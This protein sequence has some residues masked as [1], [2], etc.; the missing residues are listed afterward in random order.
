MVR[1]YTEFK[2]QF[3]PDYVIARSDGS[4]LYTLVNPVDDALMGITHVLRGEDL[5]PSTPR[6]IALYEALI[7]IGVA[8]Q[9]PQFAHLPFVMELVT[10]SFLSVIQNLTS[11][12]TVIVVSSR[13]DSSTTWPCWGGAFPL[14]AIFSALMNLLRTSMLSM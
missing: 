1:G 6:Q 10:R 9:I 3:V 4:P 14:T 11:S 12:S 7:R 13:R 5:L 8:K 2:S